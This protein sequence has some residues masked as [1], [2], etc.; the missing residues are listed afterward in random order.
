MGYIRV[1]YKRKAFNT[2]LLMNTEIMIKKINWSDVPVEQVNNKMKRQMV[3]GDQVMISRIA[4][5]DG[6]V[7]PLHH[8]E[9]EQI[10]QVVSGKMRFWL[11][12]DKSQ[13]LELEAGD[14]IIIPGN[15]PHEAVTI[16]AVIEIDTFAP[17]RQD[18]IDGTDDYLKK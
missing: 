9:N 10:T 3:Y 14:T 17:P 16:G 4:F 12:A 5:E 7:I 6:C 13:V 18:W 11:G 2:K 8:H 15:L 1:E